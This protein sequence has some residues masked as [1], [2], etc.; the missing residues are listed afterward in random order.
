M[1]ATI[2]RALAGGIL[3]GLAA[4][5]FFGPWAEASIQV[6]AVL[7]GWVSVIAT[8]GG[9]RGLRDAA[10][11]TVWG[12]ALATAALLAI[13]FFGGGAIVIAIAVG[14]AVAVALAVGAWAPIFAAQAATL[15]GFAATLGYG[16][17][18]SLDATNFALGAGP[19]T[20]IALSMLIGAV[21]GWIADVLS[22]LLGRR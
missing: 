13:V 18:R 1:N 19:F 10:I 21:L 20:T 17:V 8:G 22:S 4:W 14:A 5:L 12:A 2:V 3:A 6:W 7:I 9:L 11:G 15:L 16:Q